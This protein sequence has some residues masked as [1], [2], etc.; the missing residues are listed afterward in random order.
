MIPVPF[1]VPLI[2]LNGAISTPLPDFSMVEGTIQGPKIGTKD[3]NGRDFTPALADVAAGGYTVVVNVPGEL[4][5]PDL[6]K[7]DPTEIRRRYPPET[8]RG[9]LDTYLRTL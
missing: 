3:A 7:I 9:R 6:S 5:V 1:R 4:V 2:V 8:V